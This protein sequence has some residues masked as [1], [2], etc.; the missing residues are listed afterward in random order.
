MFL[1]QKNAIGVQAKMLPRQV[2]N[3]YAVTMASTPQVMRLM[4]VLY[5]QRIVGIG[6]IWRF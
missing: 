4:V 2:H 5:Q 6:A 3:P 1:S